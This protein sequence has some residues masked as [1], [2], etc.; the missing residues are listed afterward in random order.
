MYEV[1]KEANELLGFPAAGTGAIHFWAKTERGN[2]FH[3]SMAGFCL[4]QYWGGW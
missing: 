4:W 1:A 3:L 2:N